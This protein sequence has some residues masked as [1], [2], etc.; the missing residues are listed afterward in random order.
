MLYSLIAVKRY[1]LYHS[2]KMCYTARRHPLQERQGMARGLREVDELCGFVT[3]A[4]AASEAGYSYG[5]MH[6]LAISGN[7]VAVRL[8]DIVLVKRTSLAR[9]LRKRVAL[10]ELADEQRRADVQDV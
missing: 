7:V 9:Y 2:G 4:K 8:A 5:G 3:L 1:H 6:K 10:Q